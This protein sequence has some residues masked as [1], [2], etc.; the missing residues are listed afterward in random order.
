MISANSPS[1]LKCPEAIF[2]QLEHRF[3]EIAL[4]T[5]CTTILVDVGGVQVC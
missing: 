4:E 3:S 1:V 2:K 5:I